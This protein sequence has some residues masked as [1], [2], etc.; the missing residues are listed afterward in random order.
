[1]TVTMSRH[2]RQTVDNAFEEGHFDNAVAMLDQLRSPDHA[3][4]ILHI[5]HLVFIALHPSQESRRPDDQESLLLQS[6]RKILK[7]SKTS[8]KFSPSAVIAAQQLLMSFLDTYSPQYIGTALPKNEPPMEFPFSESLIFSQSVAIKHSR[9]CWEFLKSSFIPRTTHLHGSPMPKGK[10]KRTPQVPLVEPID[11]VSE[12]IRVV[13]DDSWFILEWLVALFEK[14]ADSVEQQAQRVYF[15]VFALL[16]LLIL[17]SIRKA[18]PSSFKSITSSSSQLLCPVGRIRTTYSSIL[19]FPAIRSA[20]SA[21]WNA[22]A[23]SGANPFI[24][25][26]LYC[27]DPHL[28]N[29]LVELTQTPY[30]NLPSFAASVLAQL[31]TINTATLSQ[32]DTLLSHLTSSPP[33]LSFKIALCKKIFEEA[34]DTSNVNR[35]GANATVVTARPTTATSAKPRARVKAIAENS[36]TTSTTAS[37]TTDNSTQNP[38]P[39][40]PTYVARLP[41]YSEMIQLVRTALP[42]FTF[43]H[44]QQQPQPPD[45]VHLPNKPWATLSLLTRVKFELLLAYT[46]VQVQRC[47]V[48][49]Q[50]PCLAGLNPP[51]LAFAQA[52]SD[53][54]FAALLHELF[55][56]RGGNGDEQTILFKDVLS[57][58]TGLPPTDAGDEERPSGGR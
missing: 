22:F 35:R 29:Q 24:F 34:S 32:F 33:A 14:D 58:L 16:L 39:A 44:P 1:M 38:L 46:L 11:N 10:G 9:N 49:E 3:P 2:L 52:V 26:L 20:S 40:S 18:F 19:R 30:L 23:H 12:D 54:S 42:F 25:D 57:A 41:S 31:T 27:T 6:P 13:S 21:L 8:I 5:L 51:D 45:S 50:Q 53:G 56:P 48:A 28:S 43:S 37:G 7:Q 17:Q 15:L 55:T 4:S 47:E 36:N